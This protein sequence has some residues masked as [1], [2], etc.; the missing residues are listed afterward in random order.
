[1]ISPSNFHLQL[2][3]AVLPVFILPP[4]DTIHNS[5][6]CNLIAKRYDRDQTT[7]VVPICVAAVHKKKIIPPFG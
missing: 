2:K 5:W 7:V 6:F 4:F 3:F 1:M